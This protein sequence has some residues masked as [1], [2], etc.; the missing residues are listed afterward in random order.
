LVSRSP[1]GLFPYLS[2]C[3]SG[4]GQQVDG[5]RSILLP[6]RF[7][8]SSGLSSPASNPLPPRSADDFSPGIRKSDLSICSSVGI[9]R[10]RILGLAPG[11]NGKR[12]PILDY[13]L[14]GLRKKS[15]QGTTGIHS[16]VKQEN[17][18]F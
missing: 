2:N 16:S 8:E 7:R 15:R 1:E 13:Y 6:A 5:L 4:F 3:G 14:R 10:A 12:K 18:Q 11:G 17:E 9:Q